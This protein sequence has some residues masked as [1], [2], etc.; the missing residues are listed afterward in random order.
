MT[1][2]LQLGLAD[3]K[4]GQEAN[5]AAAVA[6]HRRHREAAE[7]VLDELVASGQP[8][9]AEDIRRGIPTGIEA[10]SPNVLPS[11]IGTW[12]ARRRI[13]P[14]GEYRS[15]RRS[16]RASRNRVWVANPAQSAA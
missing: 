14:C 11:L 8:F 9:T 10:H 3:R 7:V 13:V 4:Q 6:A 16:R 1:D 12:A 5:L 15:R 2:Q